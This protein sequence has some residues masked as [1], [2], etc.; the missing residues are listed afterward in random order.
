MDAGEEW[1]KKNGDLWKFYLRKIY[2]G[3]SEGYGL[4]DFFSRV[5]DYNKTIFFC[6]AASGRVF[7]AYNKIGYKT[8][9]KGA[10][11]LNT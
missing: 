4:S 2:T 10:P 6:R 9:P 8:Y 3:S 11:E 7:G 1:I 5:S